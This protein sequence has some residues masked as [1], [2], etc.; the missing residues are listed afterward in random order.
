MKRIQFST[1]MLLTSL[2]LIT[3]LFSCC[4]SPIENTTYKVGDI[5][6]LKPDTIQA[7]IT[8][9]ESCNGTTLTVSY[10]DAT[11]ENHYATVREE[12]I[13]KEYTNKRKPNQSIENEY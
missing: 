3:F 4:G 2:I 7:V 13:F 5:V 9:N 1:F 12:E 10:R 11:G 6:Y 8:R